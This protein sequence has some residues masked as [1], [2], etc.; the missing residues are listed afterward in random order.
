MAPLSRLNFDH[1]LEHFGEYVTTHFRELI[2]ECPD[3]GVELVKQYIQLQSASDDGT[4]NN[5]SG[6]NRF[7]K[8]LVEETPVR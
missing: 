5:L 3:E 8:W 6:S 7:R 4:R 1:V 2:V